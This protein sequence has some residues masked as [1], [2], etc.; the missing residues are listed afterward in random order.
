MN[1]KI[2]NWDFEIYLLICLGSRCAAVLGPLVTSPATRLLLSIIC[3]KS[4]TC[5]QKFKVFDFFRRS[6]C[7]SS[8]N[9]TFLTIN[10]RNTFR[11]FG[12]KMKMQIKLTLNLKIYYQLASPQNFSRRRTDSF[13]PL[14]PHR[15]SLSPSHLLP[16]LL[17]FS[18]FVSKLKKLH[19]V[20]Q[21]FRTMCTKSHQIISFSN[22][23]NEWITISVLTNISIQQTICELNNDYL[24]L[25]MKNGD[26]FS[27]DVSFPLFNFC[28]LLFQFLPLNCTAFF[29]QKGILKIM[30]LEEILKTWMTIILCLVQ[31]WYRMRHVNPAISE[32]FSNAIC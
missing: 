21:G 1:K 27:D 30:Q 18:K 25:R 17:R 14:S 20:F 10:W 31:E 32:I 5:S 13:A 28:L 2:A 8:Q 7:F 12:I 16:F 9:S 6:N 15:P 24:I 26:L 23:Y 4:A 19:Q 3:S 22:S 11:V 29:K